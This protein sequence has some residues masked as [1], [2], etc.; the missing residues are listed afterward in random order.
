MN[1]DGSRRGKF[2]AKKPGTATGQSA[3]K[4]HHEHQGSNGGGGN[5]NQQQQQYITSPLNKSK[6]DVF[7]QTGKINLNSDG[8]IGMLDD[9][10]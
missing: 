10:K 6:Q 1:M 2:T 8:P 7:S 5:S 3:S 9:A 4:F